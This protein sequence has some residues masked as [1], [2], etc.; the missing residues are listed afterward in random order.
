M[1]KVSKKAKRRMLFSFA[2]LIAIVGTIFSS[3]MSDWKQISANRSQAK[4]LSK[5]YKKL[6]NQE[7]FL[8]AEVTKFQDP[9]YIARYAREK[10][11]YSL[12]DELIIRIPRR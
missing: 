12:P 11:L 9:E 5:E 10:Y 3:T 1:K 6:V 4:E 7:E 8:R 2:I